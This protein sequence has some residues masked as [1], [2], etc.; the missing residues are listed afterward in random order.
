MDTIAYTTLDRDLMHGRPIRVNLEGP[1]IGR[2]LVVDLTDCIKLPIRI[3]ENGSK[4]AEYDS[5][6]E[7]VQ[8]LA[9]RYPWEAFDRRSQGRLARL[10]LGEWSKEGYIDG[11]D[12]IPAFLF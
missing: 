10:V 3:Y 2:R 5:I 4:A 11:F 7:A 1:G 8:F 12:L 9:E 6:A